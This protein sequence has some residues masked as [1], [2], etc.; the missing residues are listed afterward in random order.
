M[1][2][3]PSIASMRGFTLLEVIVATAI[4][5]LSMSALYEILGTAQ[6]RSRE[7]ARRALAL[8][9]ARSRWEV[10][11][12]ERTFGVPRLE[13][14]PAGLP[15][16]S[17]ASEPLSTGADPLAPWQAE[18]GRVTVQ[19]SSRATDRVTYEGIALRQIVEPTP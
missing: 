12:L 17:L 18:L 10:W 9:E 4:L 13:R 1:N 2:M 8:Q 6:V 15:S 7:A 11:A 5:A 19:W 3:G 14:G 16:W